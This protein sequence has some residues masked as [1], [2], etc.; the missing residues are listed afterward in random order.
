ME[1]GDLV[2]DA[3]YG[4]DA[5]VALGRQSGD[6]QQT[7]LLRS[8]RSDGSEHEVRMSALLSDRSKRRAS[9]RF[10]KL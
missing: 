4:L 10:W 9:E 3:S 5:H 2:A 8:V 1:P 7:L 6:V